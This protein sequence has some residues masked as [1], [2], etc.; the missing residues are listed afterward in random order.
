M[1]STDITTVKTICH[2]GIRPP[3]KTIG[4][5]I[6][7]SRVL[8][9]KSRRFF[10][11]VPRLQHTAILDSIGHQIHHL[12]R[13]SDP[14]HLIQFRSKTPIPGKGGKFRGIASQNHRHTVI[15]PRGY[16][17]EALLRDHHA[18]IESLGK[19]TQLERR[20]FIH[21]RHL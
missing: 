19:F 14:C 21:V 8:T 2:T 17:R 10:N 15:V 3:A 9:E 5:D 12:G 16:N 6:T 1:K 20:G 7:V 13:R 4:I 18:V 11:I